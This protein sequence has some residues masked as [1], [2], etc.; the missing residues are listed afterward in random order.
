MILVTCCPSITLPV[1]LHPTDDRV[2]GELA[3]TRTDLERARTVAADADARA[4]A[5]IASQAAALRDTSAKLAAA[6]A[7][8]RKLSDA[9]AL[10]QRELDGANA[11]IKANSCRGG[12]QYV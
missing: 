5:L 11:Q 8:G 12:L 4:R 10:R 7:A 2:P 9:L 1:P 3:A 6:E